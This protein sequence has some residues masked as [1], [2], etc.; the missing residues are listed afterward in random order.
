MPESNKSNTFGFKPVA[1][2]RMS[3]AIF[4]QIRDKILS[5]ELKPNDR[6][7]SERVLIDIFQRSRPTIREA[8]RMLERSGLIMTIPGSGG[9][10]VKAISSQNVEQPLQG[11]LMQRNI[12][13]LDLYE[14]RIVNESANVIWATERRT[15]E[16]IQE[17]R[18][19]IALSENSKDNWDQFFQCDVDF[20][21]AVV[22]AGKNEMSNIV[23]RVISGLI[24]NVIAQSFTELTAREREAHRKD[25]IASHKSLMDAIVRQDAD[26]AQEIMSVHLNRFK[27]F[28]ESE[29][30][31]NNI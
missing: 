22:K 2:K 3:E 9:S 4:E 8:L 30:V 16:D 6:L 21:L 17:M 27:H 14:F 31:T 25:V 10:I 29:A 23:H 19:I 24:S 28:M 15:E 5:G 11:M 7:P 26:K 12:S 18:R 20:H 1:S 13:H